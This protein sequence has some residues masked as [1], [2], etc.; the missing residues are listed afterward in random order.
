V[1]WPVTGLEK[2]RNLNVSRKKVK[3]SKILWSK[4]GKPLNDAVDSK[5]E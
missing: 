4:S 2:I 3:E 1:V 5:E